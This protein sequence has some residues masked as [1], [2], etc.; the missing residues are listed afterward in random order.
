MPTHDGVYVRYFSQAARD[1]QASSL[2]TDAYAE[3]LEHA[4]LE[5]CAYYVARGDLAQAQ[6]MLTRSLS[7]AL[8]GNDGE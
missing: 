1:A 5:H 6:F 3:Y 8:M 2:Y 4:A 7:E